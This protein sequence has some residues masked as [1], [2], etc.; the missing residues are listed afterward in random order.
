MFCSTRKRIGRIKRGEKCR[1]EK[2]GEEYLEVRGKEKV[3]T[4][5]RVGKNRVFFILRPI[6]K[7][8]F[9]I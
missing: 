8:L 6:E 1:E 5:S 3:V 7:A 9:K 2:N 4:R